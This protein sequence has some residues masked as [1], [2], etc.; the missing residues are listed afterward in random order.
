MCASLLE[1]KKVDGQCGIELF[2]R[3]F[4][5]LA[6]LLSTPKKEEAMLSSRPGSLTFTRRA[7]GLSSQPAP[8]L[9]RAQQAPTRASYG[10]DRPP[11]P[12]PPPPPPPMPESKSRSNAPV[13]YDEP[14]PPPPPPLPRFVTDIVSLIQSGRLEREESG[15]S[16]EKAAKKES[17]IGQHWFSLRLRSR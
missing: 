12:P 16:R 4:H 1:K 8:R 3:S 5:F 2:S 7:A 15:E 10:G 14:P 9:R 11:S 6:L 13:L 17:R